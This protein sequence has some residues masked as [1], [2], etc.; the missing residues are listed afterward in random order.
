MK[1]IATNISKKYSKK[2]VINNI[3]FAI[4]DNEIVAVVGPNGTGKTTILEIMMTL[5]D[6]DQ[7]QMI[8]MNDNVENKNISKIRKK[9]GVILQEGGMYSYLKTKEILKLFASFY[10]IG[11]VRVN[12]VVKLFDLASHMSTKYQQLSGG[13]KQRVLLAIAF[14]HKPEL[15]F[16][17]EPTTGLDPAASQ[18]LWEAISIAKG[19][20]ATIILSTHSMEEVELYAD[21]VMVLNNGNIAAYDSPETIKDRYNVRFFKEAYFKILEEGESA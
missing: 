5:R 18:N 15:L 21:K 11:E 2:N 19:E 7:G 17:D 16:L 14:L 20:G 12:E 3:S 9:I 6:F 13:W 10:Q 4:D 8:L 1:V